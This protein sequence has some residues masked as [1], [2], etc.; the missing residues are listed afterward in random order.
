[1][2]KNFN[3]FYEAGQ[4]AFGTKFFYEEPLQ[5]MWIRNADKYEWEALHS[6]FLSEESKVAAENPSN[7]KYG[8]KDREVF[9][10]LKY[11]IRRVLLT[12]NDAETICRVHADKG[13]LTP[14]MRLFREDVLDGIRDEIIPL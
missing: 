12:L 3:G 4:S 10:C 2:I 6:N 5:A 14:S 11:G 8:E 7:F 13:V 1:M 9:P